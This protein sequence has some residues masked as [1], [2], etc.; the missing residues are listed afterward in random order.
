M[1]CVATSMSA[2]IAEETIQCPGVTSQEFKQKVTPGKTLIGGG[3][4]NHL[5]HQ[6]NN[7]LFPKDQNK[8]P[9]PINADQLESYLDGYEKKTTI[10][11]TRFP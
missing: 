3:I 8:M 11:I 9:T 10:L 1:E 7:P 4:K 2:I 6:N 5:S